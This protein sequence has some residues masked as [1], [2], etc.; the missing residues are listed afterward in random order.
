[1]KL[2]LHMRVFQRVVQNGNAYFL[3]SACL[4]YIKV[5]LLY[6]NTPPPPVLLSF[7]FSLPRVQTEAYWSDVDPFITILLS[8]RFKERAEEKMG[9]GWYHWVSRWV[10]ISIRFNGG[11][12]DVCRSLPKVSVSDTPPPAPP[13]FSPLTE[14]NKLA[15]VSV[16]EVQGNSRGWGWTLGESKTRWNTKAENTEEISV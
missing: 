3:Q 4:T 6:L 16:L 7:C 11:W 1:M 9:S 5:T 12:R 2:Q 13:Y 10:A 15:Q 14:G 8:C